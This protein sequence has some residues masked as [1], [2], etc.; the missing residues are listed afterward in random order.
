MKNWGKL[1]LI[2]LFCVIGIAGWYK[3]AIL[4]ERQH[5]ISSYD[6][7]SPE[8]TVSYVR[9]MVWYHSRGKLQ[10]LR[11]ILIESE[12]NDK[13]KVKLRITNMLKHRTSAYIRDFNS[14]DNKIEK[15]GNWYQDNFD[16]ENF[17]NEVFNICFNEKYTIDDKIKYVTDV[18]EEYQNMTTQKLIQTL[19]ERS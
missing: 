9:A 14:L 12:S 1:V 16:F 19:K 15:L 11:F 18:M 6:R 4:A 3:Y 10:E 5:A 7:L 13:E 17:L 2:S 8:L